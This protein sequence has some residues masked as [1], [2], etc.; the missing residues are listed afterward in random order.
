[1]GL[2]RQAISDNSDVTSIL[3]SDKFDGVNLEAFRKLR[4]KVLE[5]IESTDD[6][7]SGRIETFKDLYTKLKGDAGDKSI[8][9]PELGGKLPGKSA[10]D[11]FSEAQDNFKKGNLEIALKS[12][13]SALQKNPEL[14]K[15]KK[16]KNR[17]ENRSNEKITEN[18]FSK[19][20]YDFRNGNFEFALECCENALQRNPELSK[21]KKLKGRIEKKQNEKIAEDY[22][23]K[24]EDAFGNNSLV[25][26]LGSCENALQ[27]NPG[28]SKA[29]KLRKRIEREMMT[30]IRRF[31]LTLLKVIVWIIVGGLVIETIGT[32]LSNL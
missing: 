19:A 1:M 9:L 7:I 11:Y 29:K 13:E 17:I 10:G 23:S 8:T 31:F 3:E 26:A 2:I 28:L 24:A 20:E 32:I 12:C 16:L 27:K 22:F 30:P 25:S 14:S 4:E 15:A 21:A 5:R 6:I 18:Y